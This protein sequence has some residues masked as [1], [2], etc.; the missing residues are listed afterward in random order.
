MDID[1]L[2]RFR[3]DRTRQSYSQKDSILYALGLGY[4]SDPVSADELRFT[5]E[6]DLRA[7]PSMVNILAH[8]G[9]WVQRPEFQM[10]WRQ[11]LHAEQRF[12]ILRPLPPEGEISADY[13]VTGVVDRGAD[14][15]AWL[16]LRKDLADATGQPIARVSSTYLL[17]G[18]GGCGMFGTP[19]P[20][21]S[22]LP[23]RPADRVLR[24]T[25]LPQQALLYR[26][27]GD[28]NPLHASPEVARQAGFDRPI[29][30]GLCT[31]GIAC[32]ALISAL[33]PN[34]PGRLRHLSLRFSQPV[35]P[36]ETIET[37][38][39]DA[40]PGEVRFRARVVE[41]DVIVLDRG[42]AALAPAVAPALDEME[43]AP[44]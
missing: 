28:L 8:P 21:L 5:Y 24:H 2:R 44:T 16:Y 7:V 14:K 39:F 3:F 25:T 40:D 41:R 30:H 23:Q 29:L 34:E 37:E 43:S 33:C 11:L 27:S 13:R 32:R 18:D 15:G 17:R 6:Q 38:I 22:S 10:N 1:A 31:M 36:G 4:G 35:Y 9:L 26:L 42:R 12:D 19:E 20:A